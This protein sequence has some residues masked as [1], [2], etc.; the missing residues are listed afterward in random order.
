M[1]EIY[2]HTIYVGTHTK[3][4]YISIQKCTHPHI[5][6]SLSMF[7]WICIHAHICIGIYTHV[8]THIYVCAHTIYIY[9][10]M[11]TYVSI[12]WHSFK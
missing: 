3:N 1:N 2:M 4:L 7:V 12:K 9:V 5:P 11:C 6:L 8:Y 10:Y